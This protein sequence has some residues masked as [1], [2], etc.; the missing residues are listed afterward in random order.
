MEE[1]QRI[2]KI[3]QAPAADEVYFFDIEPKSKPRMT[4]ADKRIPRKI[5]QSYYYYADLLRWEAKKVGYLIPSELS[6]TFLLEMPKSWPQSRKDRL[7]YRP[8]QQTPDLDNLVKG[9]QDALAQQDSYIHT[10][11]HVNK[12][13]SHCPGIL[14]YI[15]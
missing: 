10:F 1:I 8:H 9:F 11:N 4:Q 7:A 14:A 15:N 12:V 2:C 5:V 6:C 3:L 13:W